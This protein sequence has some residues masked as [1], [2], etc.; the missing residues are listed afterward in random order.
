MGFGERLAA[1]LGGLG[2]S[3]TYERPGS[4]LLLTAEQWD[5]YDEYEDLQGRMAARYGPL[6]G[7]TVR[8]RVAV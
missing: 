3:E 5:I 6:D 1:V 4:G 2:D 8:G 7:F